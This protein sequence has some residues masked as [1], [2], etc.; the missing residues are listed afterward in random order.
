MD[1]LKAEVEEEDRV[2]NTSEIEFVSVKRQ[3]GIVHTLKESMPFI[4]HLRTNEEWPSK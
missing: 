4:D 1:G 3:E 2:M